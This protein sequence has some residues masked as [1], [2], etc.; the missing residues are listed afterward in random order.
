LEG[1]EA[2]LAYRYC[3]R[4]GAEY[5]EGFEVCSDCGVELV[6]EQPVQVEEEHFPALDPRHID[7]VYRESDWVRNLEPVCVKVVND[8]MEAEVIL[9]V[10]RAHELRAFPAGR[11]R[12]LHQGML[13][14][15][16]GLGGAGIRI[17]VHPDDVDAARELLALADEAGVEEFA[18]YGE[19]DIDATFEGHPLAAPPGAGRRLIRIGAFT[20]AL[21]PRVLSGL[22][23]M[24]RRDRDRISVIGSS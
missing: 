24:R 2:G 9:S 13:A 6:D 18:D 19:D 5:R 12:Y 7:Y 23:D 20:R 4:C 1:G 3:P 8:E 10:F 15:P 11:D 16:P 22:L 14:A 17:M 21:H